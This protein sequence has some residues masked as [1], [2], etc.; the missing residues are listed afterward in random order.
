MDYVLQGQGHSMFDALS[1][2]VR[3][4]FSG[5]GWSLGARSSGPSASDETTMH[6]PCL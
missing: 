3:R 4:A 6:S 2:V 1:R 5:V